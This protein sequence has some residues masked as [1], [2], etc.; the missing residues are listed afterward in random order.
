[1]SAFLL[2][3]QLFRGRINFH[4]RSVTSRPLKENIPPDHSHRQAGSDTTRSCKPGRNVLARHTPEPCGRHVCY[5]DRAPPITSCSR[6]NAM[7]RKPGAA[8]SSAL[9]CRHQTATWSQDRTHPPRPHIVKP[10]PVPHINR[11]AQG[12]LGS[13]RYRTVAATGA[14]QAPAYSH[15]DRQHDG[16]PPITHVKTGSQPSDGQKRPCLKAI[17]GALEKVTA[18]PPRPHTIPR[19]LKTWPPPAHAEAPKA[20]SSRPRNLTMTRTKA[21]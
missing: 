6:R 15:K 10:P 1:M 16:T 20:S 4:V 21:R 2:Q 12:P 13:T 3:L 5:H 14:A 18:T 8:R 7:T 11:L 9:F 19:F 17:P